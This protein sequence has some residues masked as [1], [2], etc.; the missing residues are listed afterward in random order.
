MTTQHTG[1]PPRAGAQN[2]LA[3]GSLV[4]G[5]VGAV[6][7]WIIPLVGIVLGVVAIVLG[8]VARRGGARSGQATAGVVL[9]VLAIAMAVLNVVLVV[10]MTT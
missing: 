2:G 10:N 1:T 5:I 8:A 3:I 9:G 7:A 4:T 6:M